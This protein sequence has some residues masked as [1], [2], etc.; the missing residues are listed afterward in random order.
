MRHRTVSLAL[1]G[2]AVAAAAF[3]AACTW[4]VAKDR[5]RDIRR[6]A[7][8]SP[9]VIVPGEQ[10]GPVR[11]RDGTLQE[12][13][14]ALGAPDQV[15]LGDRRF[16]ADDTPAA[17]HYV[18][19]KAG[20]SVCFV[21]G[22]LRSVSV[23]SEIYEYPG[24]PG[25]IRVGM[26]V[27]RTEAILGPMPV[28]TRRAGADFHLERWYDVVYSGATPYR[29]ADYGGVAVRVNELTGT[30]AELR[31]AAP[32]PGTGSRA[33]PSACLVEPFSEKAGADLR[34]V[35]GRMLDGTGIA[36]DRYVLVPVEQA[37]RT[38]GSS[39]S[40]ADGRRVAYHYV[41]ASLS[42]YAEAAESAGAFLA[43]IDTLGLTAPSL[44]EL[45]ARFGPPSSFVVEAGPQGY[46]VASLCYG[47][48][49]LFL[50]TARPFF[51]R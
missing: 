31:L 24:Y 19:G 41:L 38:V 45:V 1:R 49:L 3:L 37:P 7:S 43:A 35:H 23:L 15:F 51:R 18:F 30:I 28:S 11:L 27:A 21:L 33:L 29:I 22:R 48:L 16:S 14:A 8:T 47:D 2:L 50:D 39:G 20:L 4:G 5:L 32:G 34:V 26:N 46:R 6:G 12:V 25:G 40:P 13:V 42:A 44:P 17:A 9:V 10:V 36:L